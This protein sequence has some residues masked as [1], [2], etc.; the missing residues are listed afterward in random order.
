[1]KTNLLDDRLKMQSPCRIETQE[2]EGD[3]NLKFAEP[4]QMKYNYIFLHVFLSI[5]SLGLWG[6]ILFWSIDLRKRFFYVKNMNL[7]ECTH[8]FVIS[9][10]RSKEIVSIEKFTSQTQYHTER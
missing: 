7:K 10:D 2:V 9:K 8:C 1:M 6:L 4:L 3:F 5:I